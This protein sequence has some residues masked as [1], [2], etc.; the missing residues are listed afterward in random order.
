[1]TKRCETAMKNP[2]AE[3]GGSGFALPIRLKA[4]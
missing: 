4:G 3:A 1:M 2:P